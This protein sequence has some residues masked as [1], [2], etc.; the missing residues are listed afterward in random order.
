MTPFEL[1]PLDGSAV[2]RRQRRR[3]ILGI[4]GLLA[5]A[6]VVFVLV[7]FEPQ[8]AFIDDEVSETIPGLDAVIAADAPPVAS[9]PA[10]SPPSIAPPDTPQTSAAS[11]PAATSDTSAVPEPPITPV[12]DTSV[13][14]PAAEPGN[15][16]SAGVAAAQASG[17]PVVLSSAEFFS[18]E[19]TTTGTALVVALPDGSIVVRFEGLD[20]SNGPDLRV[21]LSP[22]EASDS[23]DYADRIIL[24]E[25]KGNIGDQNYVI[26]PDVDLTANRSVVIWCERFSVAF[27]AAAIDVQP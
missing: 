19:H 8:A 1:D 11:A 24:D 3:R 16:L 2:H 12:T 15:S 20:T 18:G 4:G 14:V 21:V 5:I 9:A 7:Y 10:V 22:D 23:W 13:A 26:D 17:Q 6:A 25:L 27:G